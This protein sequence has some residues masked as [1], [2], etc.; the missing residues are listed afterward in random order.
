MKAGW[1]L[2]EAAHAGREHLDAG[3]VAGCDAKALCDIVYSF[4]PAESADLLEAWFARYV[5]EAQ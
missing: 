2:D 4:E 1:I 5:C 3:F